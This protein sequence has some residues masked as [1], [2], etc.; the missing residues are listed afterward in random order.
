MTQGD[1]PE[2]L[3]FGV[4]PHICLGIHVARMEGR[5]VL[6]A[7]LDRFAPGQVHL[8]PRLRAALRPDVPRVR[9]GNARRELGLLQSNRPAPRRLHQSEIMATVNDVEAA[10]TSATYVDEPRSPGG[11]QTSTQ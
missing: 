1:A 3:T 5:V 7:M 10:L 4:G 2:H 8:S 11:E 6:E 9:P